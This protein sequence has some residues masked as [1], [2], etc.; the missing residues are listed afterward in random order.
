MAERYPNSTITQSNSHGQRGHIRP[1][2]GA[3]LTLTVV[4]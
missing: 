2:P 1:R 3:G 4:P